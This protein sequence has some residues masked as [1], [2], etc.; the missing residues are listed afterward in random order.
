MEQL[1]YFF[2]RKSKKIPFTQRKK[3]VPTNKHTLING[4][5]FSGKTFLIKDYLYQQSDKKSL[6]LD[7]DDTRI[8]I[9][10]I[11]KNLQLFIE[12]KDIEIV[13]IDN[14]KKDFPIPKAKQIILAASEPIELDGFENIKL[15]PLDFEEY[16]AFDKSTDI[17]VIFN[18]FLKNGTFPEISQL[19]DFKKDER[20][21]E[22]LRLFFKDE[23]E[24]QCFKEI[25]IMQGHKSSPYHIFTKIKPK[26]KI[27]KDRFYTF[28]ETL[29]E[30]DIIF[31][32]EKYSFPK[33][34]K[35]I[36]LCDFVLKSYLSFS[37]EFPKIFENMVF[38]EM[39]KRDYEIFYYD[40]IDFYIPK[41]QE[42]IFCIPFGSEVTIQRKIDSAYK[43]IK[44]LKVDKITVLSVANSFK[45]YE[46][47]IPVTVLPFYE[48]AIS[49]LD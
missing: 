20:F 48:W 37:K 26:I 6:Y 38:L 25:S 2:D 16:I 19:P 44:E 18:N 39:I 31:T 45:F 41:S 34:S 9:E 30:K 36:Y 10:S 1:E 17:K 23:I 4:I 29:K 12:E 11:K 3:V 47:D 33:A 40:L 46:N 8:E 28:Y 5:K 14:F 15:Y 24:L 22:M 21:F 27:S 13:A 43:Y 7:L 42:V 35:K 32:L 49:E